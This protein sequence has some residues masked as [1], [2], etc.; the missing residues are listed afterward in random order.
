MSGAPTI[1][2]TPAPDDLPVGQILQ[3]DALQRLRELPSASVDCVITSPPY[4]RLRN[5][6]HDDQLGLESHVEQWVSGLSDV[7]AEIARVLKPEGTYWLNL[8]DAYSTHHREGAPRKS[9]LAAPERLLLALME[10]GWTVR[11]KI[12]WS[13]SNP[14]PSSVRDRLSCTY[15]VVYL[16]TRSPRYHFDLDAVRVPHISRPAG[17]RRTTRES[18]PPRRSP[19]R[20][21]TRPAWLGPNA[22]GDSGLAR[23]K[24]E[25][26]VG[27]RLGKNPGDVWTL[28]TSRYRGAHFATYPEVL[29]RR[30]LQAGCPPGGIVLDPFMGSGTTAVVA[31]QLG[32]RWVGIELNRE[33]IWLAEERLERARVARAGGGS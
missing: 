26:R 16:L 5:Y 18:R 17:R 4:F 31:E 28:P 2:A 25:G 21:S 1:A 8:G 30:M 32:R 13:K 10:D 24:A 19:Q 22:D 12:V 20:H 14:T 33:Y 6:G 29:V 11:N 23:L 9:L 15:E 7:S 3:G 27:H